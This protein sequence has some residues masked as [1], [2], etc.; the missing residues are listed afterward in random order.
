[1]VETPNVRLRS[2]CRPKDMAFHAATRRFFL[3]AAHQI[4]QVRIGGIKRPSGMSPAFH[5]I[6]I[7]IFSPGRRPR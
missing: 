7:K 4:V 2:V 5:Q 6:D 3:Q 1:M